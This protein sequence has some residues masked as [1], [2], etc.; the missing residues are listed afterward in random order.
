MLIFSC[1]A[2]LGLL[3]A[4]LA[5]DS[6][7]GAGAGEHARC[8]VVT[9]PESQIRAHGRVAFGGTFQG[10][11]QVLPVHVGARTETLAYRY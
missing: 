7:R 10:E 5:V 1:W 9:A 6:I 3:V 4:S 11:S 2:L 8:Q